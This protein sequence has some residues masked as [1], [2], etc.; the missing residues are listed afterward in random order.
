MN[1]EV[2]IKVF[3]YFPSDAN[4]FETE[5]MCNAFTVLYCFRFNSRQNKSDY[6]NF[7]VGVC[8]R[9]NNVRKIPKS[10]LEKDSDLLLCS[11]FE[12]ENS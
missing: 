8:F 12:K 5:K 10:G 3:P 1:E 11:C 7:N 6:T 2:V 9:T 4:S